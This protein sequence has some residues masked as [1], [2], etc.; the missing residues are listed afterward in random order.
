MPR[1]LLKVDA[2]KGDGVSHLSFTVLEN[3]V[4]GFHPATTLFHI[5][6]TED[7]VLGALKHVE[8][9]HLGWVE[10]EGVD[11]VAIEIV[12]PFL[13]VAI[14]WKPNKTTLKD[15]I[16]SFLDRIWDATERVAEWLSKH[17]GC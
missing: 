5:T 13:L 16:G 3:V 8:L 10:F 7:D 6:E 2:A 9:F 17:L 14:G 12:I 15:R 1:R 11:H 4:L